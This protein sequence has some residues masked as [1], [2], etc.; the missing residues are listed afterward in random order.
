MVHPQNGVD[1]L[2]QF[3]VRDGLSADFD[4]RQFQCRH[5]RFLAKVVEHDR[6][7]KVV[8]LHQPLYVSARDHIERVHAHQQDLRLRGQ[9]GVVCRVQVF[10]NLGDLDRFV[11]Q[12]QRHL[13]R[14]HA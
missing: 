14:F 5:H 12:A 10:K 7:L 3:C 1:Q 4:A 9:G 8:R 6:L 11:V 2:P 13:A